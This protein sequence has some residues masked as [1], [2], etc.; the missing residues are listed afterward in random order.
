M[1]FKYK[2]LLSI[3]FVADLKQSRNKILTQNVNKYIK[4]IH[5]CTKYKTTH[6]SFHDKHKTKTI[7]M[8][9]IQKYFQTFHEGNAN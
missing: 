1:K 6:I 5:I 4:T 9:F 8:A 2:S 3:N 7:Y